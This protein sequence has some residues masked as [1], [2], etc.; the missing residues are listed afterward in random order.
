MLIPLLG[1]WTSLERKSFISNCERTYPGPAT[2]QDTYRICSCATDKMEE[3]HLRWGH[4][5][6]DKKSYKQAIKVC[7]KKI[8]EKENK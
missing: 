3:L 5:V 7:E 8:Q 1:G 6:L 2:F 4:A